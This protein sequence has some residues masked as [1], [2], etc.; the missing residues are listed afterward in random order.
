MKT[1]LKCTKHNLTKEVIFF[2]ALEVVREYCS[3]TVREYYGTPQLIRNFRR[4]TESHQINA[5][6]QLSLVLRFLGRS[7]HI[8]PRIVHVLTT[9]RDLNLIFFL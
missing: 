4:R 8:V 9:D 3:S 6:V 5:N 2:A 7:S 1:T